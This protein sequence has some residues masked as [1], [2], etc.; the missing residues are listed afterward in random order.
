VG[1]LGGR[2]GRG[3]KDEG[4]ATVGVLE[5]GGLGGLSAWETNVGAAGGGVSKSAPKKLF[6]RKNKNR[7]GNATYV[8]TIFE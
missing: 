2:E 3:G 8:P 6:Q 5:K 1:R 7:K 4:E